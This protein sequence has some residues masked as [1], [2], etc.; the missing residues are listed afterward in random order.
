MKGEKIAVYIL[1][2]PDQQL[3][4]IRPTFPP[5]F[6]WVQ[7]RLARVRHAFTTKKVELVGAVMDSRAECAMRGH[8]AVMSPSHDFSAPFLPP[9]L[10]SYCLSRPCVRLCLGTVK[11]HQHTTDDTVDRLA[12]QSLDLPR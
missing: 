7:A 4:Q 5:I 10:N 1:Y 8:A 3:P 9:S 6:L 2:F 11:Q 12:K